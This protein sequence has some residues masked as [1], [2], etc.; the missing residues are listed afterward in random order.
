MKQL[1]VET[2]WLSSLLFLVL[3]PSITNSQQCDG[4]FHWAPVPGTQCL[5]G[6]E[7]G[8]EYFCETGNPHTPLLIYLDGGGLCWNADTCFCPNDDCTNNPIVRNHYGLDESNDLKLPM[9]HRLFGQAAFTG[10]HS[11][12]IEKRTNRNIGT[13]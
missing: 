11:P 4:R 10:D 8:F 9:E 12:F 1:R 3:L 13:W 5:N 2:M 6:S 7:T